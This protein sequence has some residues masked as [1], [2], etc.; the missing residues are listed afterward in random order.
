MPGQGA[1]R[2][3]LLARLRAL[4]WAAAAPP[5]AV[6]PAA[7]ARL[8]ARSALDAP[9]PAEVVASWLERLARRRR[10]VL[11]RLAELEPVPGSMRQPYMPGEPRPRCSARCRD[12][13][14][15]RAPVTWC[16]TTREPR[17]RCRLHGGLSTGPRTPEGRAAIVASNQRRAAARRSK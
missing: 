13:H 10:R 9:P 17:Q 5:P 2:A 14:P 11:A 8:L 6:D 16:P 3:E 7:L 1:R 15:C 4:E 12:G